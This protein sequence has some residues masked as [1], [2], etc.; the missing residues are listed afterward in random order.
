MHRT[1]KFTNFFMLGS[2]LDSMESEQGALQ[3]N[4]LLKNKYMR[5]C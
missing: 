3:Q 4:Y 5:I 2:F 1:V